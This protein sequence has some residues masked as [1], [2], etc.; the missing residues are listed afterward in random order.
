MPVKTPL[1]GTSYVM[2]HTYPDMFQPTCLNVDVFTS[3]LEF[4]GA[5]TQNIWK[6]Y[7]RSV[8]EPPILLL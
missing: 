8:S 6:G 3:V 7:T 2:K 1:T 5:L 4:F